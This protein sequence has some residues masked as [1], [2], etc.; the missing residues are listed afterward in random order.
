MQYKS[1]DE[2]LGNVIKSNRDIK[3][4]NHIKFMISKDFELHINITKE[5]KKLKVGR[6]KLSKFI[7]SLVDAK[8]LYR[9]D[10]GFVSNS[11]M[12]MP[13]FARDVDKKQE[14]WS[15]LMKGLTK[16]VKIQANKR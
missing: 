16:W 14:E 13:A 12:F 5:A 7:S 4:I 1:Y 3:L 9:T 15:E 6:D 8:F 2:M 10:T 11:H